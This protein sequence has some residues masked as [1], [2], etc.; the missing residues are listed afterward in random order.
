MLR[1]TALA[2]TLATAAT[3]S[4]SACGSGGPSVAKCEAQ[5][6][7]YGMEMV[8][9]DKPMADFPEPDPS[10]MKACEGLSKAEQGAVLA[11]V[12]P[13]LMP[14]IMAKAF[15]EAGEEMAAEGWGDSLTF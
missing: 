9:S 4:L 7:A 11:K 15:A 12:M 3:L 10:Q 13:T 14:L 1:K 8:S 6:M 2:L 5:I